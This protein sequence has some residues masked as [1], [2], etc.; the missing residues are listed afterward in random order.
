MSSHGRAWKQE[1][2]CV[3]DV[4]KILKNYFIE[5]KRILLSC[6][7]ESRDLYVSTTRITHNFS[8]RLYILNQKNNS[9]VRQDHTILSRSSTLVELMLTTVI[10]FQEKVSPLSRFLTDLVCGPQE[11][12]SWETY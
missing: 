4:V 1:R 10:W 7:P 8:L 12:A 5:L 6:P 11:V 3:Y 2:D 9:S